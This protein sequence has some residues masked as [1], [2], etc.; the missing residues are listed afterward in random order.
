MSAAS[1][2]GTPPHDPP[3]EAHH[4]PVLAALVLF[5]NEY[6]SLTGPATKLEPLHRVTSWVWLWHQ[7]LFLSLS[8]PCLDGT[9]RHGQCSC[10]LFYISNL[11]GTL[12]STNFG[13]GLCLCVCLCVWFDFK[14]IWCVLLDIKTTCW[15][16]CVLPVLSQ[17]AMCKRA[18]AL[19]FL[20]MVSTS[21]ISSFLWTLAVVSRLPQNHLLSRWLFRAVFFIWVSQILICNECCIGNISH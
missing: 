19:C 16:H 3:P 20:H 18:M 5:E 13:Q 4:G 10:C 11:K 17:Y 1:C 14:F 7:H 6:G 15:T 2:L 12:G 21:V 9:H 8:V